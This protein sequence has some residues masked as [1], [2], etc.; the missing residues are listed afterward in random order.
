MSSIRD[1]KRIYAIGVSIVVLMASFVIISCSKSED[2]SVSRQ[3]TRQSG[4]I[5]DPI[6]RDTVSQV[7][8]L[9][10]DPVALAHLGDEYFERQQFELAIEAYQKAIKLAPDDV[11]TLNDLGLALYYRGRSA[12][13]A[14]ILRKGTEVDP[15]FQRVWLSLGFVLTAMGRNDEAR[16]IL[17]KAAALDPA[18]PVGQEAKRMADQLK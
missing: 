6:I 2:G 5:V 13:A 16:P 17:E 1:R 18:S 9:P 15:S 7:G 8:K 11:D 14:D 3:S 4:P 12:E 10:D